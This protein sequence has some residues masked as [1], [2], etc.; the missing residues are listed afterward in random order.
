MTLQF[1]Y[2]WVLYIL[3]MVPV[4]GLLW[5]LAVNRRIA[6][7]AG[8]VAAPMAARLAPATNPAR[9]FWQMV[10]FMAALFLSLIAA[11]RPQWGIQ[12]ETVSQ[13][14]RDLL[15][16]LDVSR[17]MLAND[18]HPSRL[19]RAKVDLLDLVKQLR[20]DRAGLIAFR[21]RPILLCPLTT[22]YGFLTQ[23]LEGAGPHSA[24]RGETSIGDAIDEALKTFDTNAGAHR[25]IVLV[26]DGED[27]AGRVEDAIQK[28]RDQHVAIF[29]VGFGSSEGSTLPSDSDRKAAL[30]YQGTQVISK[31]N[32]EL[33]SD[34]ATRTGGAYVPVGMANVKLGNLYRDHLSRIAAQDLEESL[35]RRYVERYQ[36]F[37]L[38]AVLCLLATAFLSKGQIAASVQRRRSS[39]SA[40]ETPGVRD[41]T[42][43]SPTLKNLAAICFLLGCTPGLA[44]AAGRTN[45]PPATPSPHPAVTNVPPGRRGAR[46]AQHLYFQGKYA[47]SAAAYQAAAQSGANRD[48][49]RFNAGCAYLKA[50]QMDNAANA[51]RSV[52]EDHKTEATA[53]AYNLGCVLALEATNAAT[54]L[55]GPDPTAAEKRVKQL[56][57]AGTA[58]QR[59]LRLDPALEDGRRN[60]AAVSGKVP[61]AESQAKIARLMAQHQQTPP[62]ALAGEMLQ[63]QR[64][65]ME[66][67]PAAFSNTTP[68]LIT[69][70]ERLAAD[71]ERNGD[72]LIPLKGKLMQTLSQAPA[73][74][75]SNAPSPQQ[76][77]AQVDAFV[78]SI[79]DRMNA[80]AEE[81][82]NLDRSAAGSS[83][84]TESS[85]YHLWKGIA[86]YPG[87]LQEDLRRQTNNIR[88]STSTPASHDQ[89]FRTRIA[90]EQQEA[91]DL[92]SLFSARFEQQVPPEGLSAPSAP[93]RVVRPKGEPQGSATNAVKQLIT[94]ETRTT[95]LRLANDALVSQQHA[96]QSIT[97]SIP[98]SVPAQRE[99]Y[100]LLKEI[101]KLLPKQEPPP[102]QNQ[103]QQQDQQQNPEQQPQQEPQQQETSQRPQ[104]Q[105]QPK[106]EEPKDHMS[107]ESAQRVI[108][109]A[110]QR[111]KEHEQ[112][113]QERD[114]YM[115]LSP[116]E[117]D[118]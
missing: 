112:A 55:A 99:A 109:K 79:R 20:G 37:L 72:L 106:P 67:I 47:E 5:H 110:R 100:Q 13:K 85:V 2:P 36:L 87:L 11:A 49:W 69:D 103:Q 45:V 19:G 64:H 33:L 12:E 89:T 71:Q 10:L 75:S 91:A 32:H 57:Q 86:S 26:S 88:I 23:A 80:T 7:T 41:L 108:E 68:A 92:T 116:D 39:P 65:I 101:E 15:I 27:L 70:L 58:L 29:T 82:R 77:M 42:P 107:K 113:K 60:L 102:Q 95:I 8:L 78:E 66:T 50:G 25:A 17:S 22:D 9:R 105:E 38:M 61:E 21:G 114:T 51:F 43:P 46:I 30:I 14:G 90:D 98:S 28:A 54:G 94:P 97:T 63:A 81:L 111:E 118:W 24:P 83:T 40:T 35:Q 59:A 1:Q 4:A 117:R 34:I 52:S 18:V 31:L 53:A 56:K 6:P 84:E 48:A 16:V 62:D 76:Q 44:P 74:T 3:W 73:S 93:S 96:R 115:P 104:Q